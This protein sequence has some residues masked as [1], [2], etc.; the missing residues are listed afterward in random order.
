MFRQVRKFSFQL[1]LIAKECNPIRTFLAVAVLTDPL[2]ESIVQ[3]GA[4]MESEGP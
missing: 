4:E 1:L 2:Q 3:S